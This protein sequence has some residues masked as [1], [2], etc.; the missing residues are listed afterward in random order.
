MPADAVRIDLPNAT[1][2]PGLIDAHTHLTMDPKF[3]Y[4]RTRCFYPASNFD[5]RQ[6][7]PGYAARPGFTTV[8]NVGA[9]GYSDVALRDAINAGDV[10]GPRMLVSGPPLSITGGHADNNLLLIPYIM[11]PPTAWPTASTAS[12]TWFGRTS[13]MAWT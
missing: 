2:L 7:R 10:P 9:S 5:W 3:G 1:V 12:V 8:R 6:E 11:R 4:E 13:S